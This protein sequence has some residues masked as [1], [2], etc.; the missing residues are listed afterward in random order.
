ME[1]IMQSILDKKFIEEY[2]SRKD[3]FYG[4][5]IGNWIM[6]TQLQFKRLSE[7]TH[8]TIEHYYNYKTCLIKTDLN[9]HPIISLPAYLAG[10]VIYDSFY[11][12]NEQTGF[13]PMDETLDELKRLI[14]LKGLDA[15][16]DKAEIT[17]STKD[18][19]KLNSSTEILSEAQREWVV[20][21]VSRLIGD[22]QHEFI[23]ATLYFFQVYA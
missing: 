6:I 22:N 14:Y 20:N 16:Q 13:R 4:L 23:D 12:L 17:Y 15:N 8:A 21:N 1:A 7:E 18:G 9:I 3:I 19:V 5:K 11:Y 10:R 2:E